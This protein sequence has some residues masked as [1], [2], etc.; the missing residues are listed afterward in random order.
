MFASML[1][2]FFWIGCGSDDDAPQKVLSPQVDHGSAD[3]AV[4]RHAPKRTPPAAT[5]RLFPAE[6]PLQPPRELAGYYWS[7]AR[8]HAGGPTAC[9]L[10]V[11]GYAESR[12]SV[13]AVS[14]AGAMGVAQ[15]LPKTAMDLGI[16]PFDPEESIMAQAQYMRWCRQAWT[17][18][19]GGRTE[20]DVRR[21]GLAT[22]NWGRGNMYRSQER[23]GWTL[24]SEAHDYLPAE[25]QHYVFSIDPWE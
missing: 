19:L 11:Q 17:P 3:V 6:C 7:A 13:V 15:F 5:G 24:Y 2:F 25:T 9:E 12:W 20:E 18:G 21:L 23:H 1:C 14:P 8:R 22:Y 4:A 16:D 10:A